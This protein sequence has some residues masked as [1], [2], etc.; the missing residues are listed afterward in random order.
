MLRCKIR[1]WNTGSTTET[2][3]K[4]GE[5]FKELS[6]ERKK[7]QYLYLGLTRKVVLLL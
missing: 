7:K 1:N 6:L 3:F 5:R 2:T 4:S